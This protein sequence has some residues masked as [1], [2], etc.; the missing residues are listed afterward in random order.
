MPDAKVT[1]F[2]AATS[3]QAVEATEKKLFPNDRRVQV[4][5]GEATLRFDTDATKVYLD[6]NG[7]L[8]YL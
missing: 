7:S 8:G 5:T 6:A 1:I 2:M 3:T 4:D